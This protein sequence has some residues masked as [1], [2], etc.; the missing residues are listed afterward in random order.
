MSKTIITEQTVFEELK[1]IIAETLRVD[2]NSI[3]LDS[4]LTTELDAESLDIVEII[5]SIEEEFDIEIP[6]E[7]A[8]RKVTVGQVIKYIKDKLAS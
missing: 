1:K 6:D 5:A 2:E 8:E 4:S 3:K 7:E